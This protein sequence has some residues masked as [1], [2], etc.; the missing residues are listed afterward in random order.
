MNEQNT[1]ID[2]ITK[3]YKDLHLSK[4]VMHTSTENDKKRDRIIKYFERL[5]RVQ[6]KVVESKSTSALAKLKEFYYDLYVIKPEN[7]PDKYFENEQRIMRTKIKL[8]AFIF[9]FGSGF[10]WFM[11]KIQG[12]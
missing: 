7:I 3:L 12:N 4:R 2:I 10:L 9:G 1:W 5:E 8:S 6:N 11:N